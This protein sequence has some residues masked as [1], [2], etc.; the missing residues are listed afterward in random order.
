MMVQVWWSVMVAGIVAATLTVDG[1]SAAGDVQDTGATDER[2]C[3]DRHLCCQGKNNT[4]RVDGPR[5]SN[6]D[7]FTCF[8]DS[9][10]DE[11][12]DCC[13]DYK[14]TCQPVDCEVGPW[15]E[16][17]E[18]DVRCGPGVRQ[19]TRPVTVAPLNGGRACPPTVQ[20]TACDGTRCK[21]P[22]TPGAGSELRE[23][24]KILPAVFG[25]WRYDKT[26]N[27][28]SDI[29]KNLFKHYN[30]NLE[31]KMLPSYCAE[32]EVV[33]AKPGCQS[34]SSAAPWT[35]PLIKG[36]VACVECQSV[37]MRRRL[38][39]RCRGHGVVGR[40]TRW[41]A[42]T[43]PGCSG[44]WTMTSARRQCRCNPDSQLSFIFI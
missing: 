15:R 32:Y 10:C 12:G 29:R 9:A 22:R 34:R 13:I 26:Y 5:V 38:G 18:C 35:R 4:C 23:T 41:N 14:S 30:S 28:Y 3:A 20:K 42:A 11:L 33:D 39:N 2:G 25:S 1:L 21:Y 17:G 31:P 24:G 43:A 27:P 44:R 6:R 16:W 40:Q 37:A 8:C 19:R 7:S 36:A